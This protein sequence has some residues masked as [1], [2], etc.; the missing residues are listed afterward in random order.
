MFVDTSCQDIDSVIWQPIPKYNFFRFPLRNMFPKN[1]LNTSYFYSE[2]TT[3]TLQNNVI[4]KSV[5]KNDNGKIT[6]Y[7]ETIDLNVSHP[8]KPQSKKKH[9]RWKDI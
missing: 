3:T 5:S 7:N 4:H 8:Q 2:N 6:K 9:I 1:D